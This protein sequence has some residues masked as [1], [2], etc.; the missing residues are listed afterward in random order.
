MELSVEFML[1]AVAMTYLIVVQLRDDNDDIN[2][3]T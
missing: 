2:G 3:F 1:F